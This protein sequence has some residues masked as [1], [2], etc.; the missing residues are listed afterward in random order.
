[1]SGALMHTQINTQLPDAIEAYISKVISRVIDTVESSDKKLGS[2][3]QILE[4]FYKNGGLNTIRSKC[5]FIQ[6][7]RR[8]GLHFPIMSV[9]IGISV[10][11]EK[12]F[13]QKRHA[14]HIHMSTEARPTVKLYNKTI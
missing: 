13:V 11:G 4:S 10:G 8:F 9:L 2:H 12:Q 7:R 1:M 14:L 3:F 5:N 6:N